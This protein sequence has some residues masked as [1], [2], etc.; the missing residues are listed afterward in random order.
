MMNE[1]RSYLGDGVFV[2]QDGERLLLSTSNGIVD[3]NKIYLEPEVLT[4]LVEYIKQRDKRILRGKEQ[5]R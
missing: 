4:E 2:E 3:T 5:G 1:R